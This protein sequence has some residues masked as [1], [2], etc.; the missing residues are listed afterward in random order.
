MEASR[1]VA[2]SSWFASALFETNSIAMIIV[3]ATAPKKIPRET[4]N[5][6]IRNLLSYLAVT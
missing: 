1:Q 6:V 2:I 3:A 4:Y 5:T